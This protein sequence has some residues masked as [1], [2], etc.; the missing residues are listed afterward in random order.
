MELETRVDEP[1]E[2]EELLCVRCAGSGW[3]R[4]VVVRDRMN[5]RWRVFEFGA[6]LEPVDGVVVD[7]GPCPACA[8]SE[9]LGSVA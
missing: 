3:L 2:A 1:D 5:Q 9:R 8:Y 7:E 6:G 4:R